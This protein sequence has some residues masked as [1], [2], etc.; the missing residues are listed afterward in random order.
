MVCMNICG[1]NVV[2]MNMGREKC[3]LHE[4]RRGKCGFKKKR[5]RIKTNPYQ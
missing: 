5:N 1:E 4:C 2:Y 3:G